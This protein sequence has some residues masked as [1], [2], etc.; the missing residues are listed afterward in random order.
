[1]FIQEKKR[2]SIYYVSQ[3]GLSPIVN[4]IVNWDD[5]DIL[6]QIQQTFIG[7]IRQLD[8]RQLQLFNCPISNST[9]IGD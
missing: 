5:L 1:M 7:L 9:L 2:L 3:I 6:V 4:P 8:T